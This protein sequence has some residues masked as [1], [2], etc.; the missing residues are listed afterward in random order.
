MR[1]NTIIKE[2]RWSQTT[3]FPVLEIC[4]YQRLS[5]ICPNTLPIESPM[6]YVSRA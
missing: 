2:K 3:F 5:S 4:F 1:Y 6:T